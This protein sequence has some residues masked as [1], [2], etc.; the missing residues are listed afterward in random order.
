MKRKL[1]VVDDDRSVCTSLKKLFE[2]EGF[3]V[4]TAWDAAQAIAHFRASSIDLVVLDVNL[5]TDDGWSVFQAMVDINPLVPTVVITAEYGQRNRAI[6]AGVEA[7]IEKPIDVPSLLEL[8]DRL[9]AEDSEG[10]LRR[11]C[12]EES[13][14]RY[15]AKDHATFLKLLEE[16]RSVPL[17][18]PT[19]LRTARPKS[20]S[21]DTRGT[22]ASPFIVIGDPTA[23]TV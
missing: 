16:R 7:L 17:N 20:E 9:L 13:Y 1:L 6:A 19:G 18:L 8:I 23:S 2:G 12:G 14:C 11:V 5:G 4:F 10:R 21:K 22:P 15:V 3:E